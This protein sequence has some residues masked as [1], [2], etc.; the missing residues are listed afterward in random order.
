MTQ[1]SGGDGVQLNPSMR[2]RLSMLNT[3][4]RSKMVAD[5]GRIILL[6]MIVQF[7]ICYRMQDDPIWNTVDVQSSLIFFIYSLSMSQKVD[8]CN[9]T[10]ILIIVIIYFLLLTIASLK[11]PRRCTTALSSLPVISA[12]LAMFYS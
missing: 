5:R 10:F 12:C 8:Q 4:V 3:W 1:R 9:R 11:A 6:V 7:Y 2:E